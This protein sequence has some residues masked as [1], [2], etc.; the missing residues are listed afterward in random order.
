[1]RDKQNSRIRFRIKSRNTGLSHTGCSLYQ[2]TFRTFRTRRFQRT[3][4]L[5]LRSARFVNH[6]HICILRIFLIVLIQ[7]FRH[8]RTMPIFGISFEFRLINHGR[9]MF[10]KI[11]KRLVKLLIT[12]RIRLTVKTIIPL[13]SRS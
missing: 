1:M 4:H 8:R 12:L 9:M 10:K 2:R 6:A 11:L 13:D 5:D 7:V 3:K